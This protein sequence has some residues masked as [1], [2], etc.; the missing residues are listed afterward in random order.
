MR[1]I[2]SLK[3]IF[4]SI[5]SQIVIIGLS[6]ISRKVF[7]DS[8]GAEYLGIN[9][10][11]TNVISAMVLI[12]SGI[13]ISI[14]YNL[15]KPLAENDTQ[16]ITALIQLYKKAYTVLAGI[17]LI[18]SLCLIPFVEVILNTEESIDGIYLIYMIFVTQSM[19][20]YL[21]GH[22]W[23]LVSADQKAYILTFSNTIIQIGITISKII[24]IY[25]TNSYILYLI[26][27]LAI[28]FIGI[29]VKTKIVHKRY[30]YIKTKVK[31][32]LDNT[33]VDNITTNVKAMFFHNIGGYLV[34]S[35]DN[36]LMSIFISVTSV[37][38]YSNYSMIITQLIS[39]MSSFVSGISGSIGNLIATEGKDKIY[40]VFLTTFLISFWINSLAVIFLYNLLE[41]FITWWLGSGLL[42]DKSVFIVILINV[43]LT[44][45]RS[46]I[47]NFKVKAGLFVQDKYA[48]TLEGI[49]NIV[50]SIAL[51]NKFGLIGVF[52]GTTISTLAIPFWNQ[53]RITYKYEFEKNVWEY[54]GRFSMFTCIAIIVGII[55]TKINLAL[56]TGTSFLSLVIS[57]VI[58]CV[59]P[60]IIY[61]IIFYRTHEFTYVKHIIFAQYLKHTKMRRREK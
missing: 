47:Y 11:L 60:N 48:S 12:E 51:I 1:T 46:V 52:L 50:I 59:I 19:L 35:T 36:I 58:C 28:T 15:Y 33:T 24:V 57:G 53:A 23:A 18:F 10:V 25:T 14:V 40:K 34:N 37:G 6:F 45:I 44:N 41:P 3:N 21:N 54:Y 43:Y 17:L 2:N 38:L 20:G 26:V 7:L 29:V 13:A 5:F 9:G 42:L 16:K 61:L 32:S 49:L 39:F 31:Y 4:V 30:P 55:T 56:V 22:K 27:E 8:L